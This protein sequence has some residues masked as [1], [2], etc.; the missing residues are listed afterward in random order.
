[1]KNLI[2]IDNL[3]E[4]LPNSLSQ[5]TTFNSLHVAGNPLPNVPEDCRV[6]GGVL[7]NYLQGRSNGQ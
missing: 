4:D 7:W 5:I 3:I 2:L 6:G 1:M